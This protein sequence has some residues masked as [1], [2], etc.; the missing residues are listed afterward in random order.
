MELQDDSLSGAS[1]ELFAKIIS[2]SEDQDHC[3]GT[4]RFTFVSPGLRRLFR[5]VARGEAV[6]SQL[7][8]AKDCQCERSEAISAFKR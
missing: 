2:V 6:S 5:P 8:A 3:E 1:G 4:V 7:R